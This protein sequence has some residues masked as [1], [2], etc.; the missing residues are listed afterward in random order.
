MHTPHLTARHDAC[1]PPC[2]ALGLAALTLSACSGGGTPA[3][4]GG[5]EAN[6]Q[7]PEL[8]RDGTVTIL[9]MN[10]LWPLYVGLVPASSACSSASGR[11][12]FKSLPVHESMK[13]I[14]ELI[15][16]TCKA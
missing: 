9:G 10:G 4:H 8:L 6:L 12:A 16:T 7:L 14:S 5:G 13:Q 15:Y 2:W 3:E 11:T 1:G